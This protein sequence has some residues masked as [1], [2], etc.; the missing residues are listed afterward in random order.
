MPRPV[1]DKKDDVPKGFE[2]EYEE[3]EGKW[4]PK[5]ADNAELKAALAD[6]R[7]LREAAEKLTAKAANDRADLERRLAAASAGGDDKD[8]ALIA[9]AL[10]KF[11]SDLVEVKAAAAAEVA[12]SKAELR[13]LKLDDKVK[14][15]FLA[16]GGRSERADKA[17][18]DT[19]ERFDLADDGR[20]VVKDATGAPTTTTV[21][22][23]FGKAYRAEMAEF[24]T[25]TKAA[26]GAA[27]GGANLGS[28][29]AKG[30]RDSD[31]VITNPMGVL[32]RANA[33]A[34]AAA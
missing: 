16:A 28:I 17:L 8:R 15:A 19:K 31:E 22:D 2:D 23:F 9:K 30:A 11:D 32:K 34:E 26:G 20:I 24:Y 10:A 33:E 14:A 13:T 3:R 18:R 4:H 1:Y 25:G 12:A 7:R 27:K 29:P 6:E 21:E 5:A